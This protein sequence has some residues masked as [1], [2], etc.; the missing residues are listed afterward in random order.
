LL[1]HR[2]LIRIFVIPLVQGYSRFARFRHQLRFV[3]DSAEHIIDSTKDTHSDRNHW[4]YVCPD[5]V[6]SFDIGGVDFPLD[7]TSNTY[8]WSVDS[9]SVIGAN[10]GSCLSDRVSAYIL[11]QNELILNPLASVY[12]REMNFAT[13]E[14]AVNPSVS[15]LISVRDSSTA[16]Q[17]SQLPLVEFQI[18]TATFKAPCQ[19]IP[20]SH[21]FAYLVKIILIL[22]PRGT[23][24]E[25]TL[26]SLGEMEP[27]VIG[28]NTLRKPVIYIDNR[29]RQIGFGEIK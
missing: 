3:D 19:R 27:W 14:N 2:L 23:S 15:G 28:L 29:N 18:G 22:W 8:A 26:T 25:L 13:S 24:C 9:G 12:N 6:I 10:F 17:V 21:I 1:Y 5:R 11:T 7:P 20:G 4:P 16:A